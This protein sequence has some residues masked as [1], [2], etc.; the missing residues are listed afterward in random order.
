MST[1]ST[2]TDH[3]GPNTCPQC[4][5][6]APADLAAHARDV[7]CQHCGRLLWFVRRTSGNAVILTFQ[8]GLIVGSECTQRL[9]EVLAA[10]AGAPL[11]VANLSQLPFMSSLF[12][13]MLVALDR[14][15]KAA[16][17]RLKLCG[18]RPQTAEALAV[19]KLDT[20]F[21][22]CTDEQA[23]LAE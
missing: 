6:A 11:V 1:S 22:I 3:Q 10:V 9:G 12:L 15:I 18:L 13:G 7:A 5:Q 14:R 21:K 17:N 2:V 4:G 16:G 8:P 23:A 20:V 19:A